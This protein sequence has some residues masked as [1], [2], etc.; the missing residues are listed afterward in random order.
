MI[1][2]SMASL[3]RDPMTP[4]YVEAQLRYLANTSVKPVT[5][6]PRPGTGEPRRG[7][8]YAMFPVRIHNS[9]LIARELLMDTNGFVLIRNDTD[10]RDFYDETELRNVYYKEVEQLVKMATGAAK[11]VVFDHTIRVADRAVERG[12]RAPVQIVH[13]DYTEK[14]GP[15]RGRDILNPSEAAARLQRR[16]ARVQRLAT[17]RRARADVPAGA[18]RRREHC[19]G[20][21]RHR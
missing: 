11:V 8:N 14:S 10:V 5:Y 13:N 16:F 4:G 6:N 2:E 21:P 1:V 7:G 9:R 3:A 17:D 15:Q 18:G 19:S 20:G 12:L